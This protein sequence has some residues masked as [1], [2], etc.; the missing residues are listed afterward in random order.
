M[1]YKKTIVGL[2]F[3][4]SLFLTSQAFA[5]WKQTKIAYWGA[6]GLAYCNNYENVSIRVGMSQL[7]PDDAWTALRNRAFTACQYRGGLYDYSG[8][9]YYQWRPYW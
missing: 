7:H 8:R 6:S 5:G 2:V 3:F 4:L 9:T 1:F